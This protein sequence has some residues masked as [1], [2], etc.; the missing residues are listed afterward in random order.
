M[1]QR[2]KIYFTKY[3]NFYVKECAPPPISGTGI[4]KMLMTTSSARSI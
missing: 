2:E 1:T 4:G 3:W